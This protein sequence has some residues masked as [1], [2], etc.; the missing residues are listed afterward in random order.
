MRLTK[1]LIYLL[2]LL[3]A[4]S[5]EERGLLVPYQEPQA[6]EIILIQKTEQNC[7]MPFT[8][9][10]FANVANKIGSESYVWEIDGQTYVGQDALIQVSDTGD[11]PVKLTVS[12]EIGTATRS[13]NFNYLT[14]SLPVIADFQI[15]AQN[16][17]FRAP[18]KIFFRDLS[19]RATS[20]Q[21]DFGDG[22]QSN[23]SNPEH[24]YQN[25]GTYTVKITA[26]CP[27]DTQSKTYTLIIKDE[28]RTIRFD[29][30]TLLSFPKNYFPEDQDDNTYGA[31]LYLRLR[32]N[33]F[34]YGT[35]D[36]YSNKSKAP[37]VWEI[38]KNWNNDYRLFFTDFPDYI[39]EFW[40]R[41]DN[42]DIQIL[43]AQFDGIY[44]KSEYYPTQLEYSS[45]DLKV[46]V[47]FA[48]ED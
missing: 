14:T 48:Y 40:D 42:G 1:K 4:C 5:Q 29:K 36:V 23:L 27:A 30:V 22:Y 32:H 28:P 6:P 8:V 43:S 9:R 3:M 26:M 39:M 11:V 46:R 18:A 45:G 15:S 19:Q 10:F 38:P 41:N 17:N 16:N 13:T 20:V 31:D 21:W 25:D 24:I 7:Q 44:L 35:S 12:N 33:N 37:L 34:T 47:Q 2:P